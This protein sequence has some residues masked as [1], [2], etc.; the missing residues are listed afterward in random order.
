MAV[1]DPNDMYLAPVKGFKPSV[2]NHPSNEYNFAAMG[3]IPHGT[4]SYSRNRATYIPATANRSEGPD[5]TLIR[6]VPGKDDTVESW[7]KIGGADAV[8]DKLVADK[9]IKPVMIMIGEPRGMSEMPTL[10]ADDFK[11]W[12]E[13]RKA[14]IKMLESL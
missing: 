1:A 14:L 7:F 10:K 8:V 4:V 12:P 13:R 2:A 6:L 9:K 11:T 3:D 5:F